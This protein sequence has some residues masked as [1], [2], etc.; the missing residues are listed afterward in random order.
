MALIGNLFSW[1]VTG[2]FGVI[3]LLLAF[4]TW[5]LYTNHE[6]ITDYVRPAV[7]SYPGFAFV[8]AVVIGI[9]LGHFLWGPATGRTSPTDQQ[10]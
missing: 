1:L 3:T 2:F 6:P 5:A 9:L 4:E 7:H 10:R 8:I